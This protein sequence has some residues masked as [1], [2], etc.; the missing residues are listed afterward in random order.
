MMMRELFARLVSVVGSRTARHHPPSGRTSRSALAIVLAALASVAAAGFVWYQK[1]QGEQRDDIVKVCLAATTPASQAIF[2]YDYRTFD[3]AVANARSYL[4]G[5]FL[6]D[7]LKTTTGLKA[8]A[9]QAQAVVQAQVSAVGV[10][11]ASSTEV[12]VL[13][14]L[15]QYR[16]NANITG[17]KVDQNRVVL[18]MVRTSDGCRVSAA[19]AI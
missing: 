6:D 2:S 1:D 11:D 7:Y 15:N 19:T 5:G 8:T 10:V 9:V 3:A 17:E 4:T 12:D 18:S 13:V 14:Y 16:R